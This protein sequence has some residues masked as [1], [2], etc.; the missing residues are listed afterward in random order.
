MP[1]TLNECC[2]C[3]ETCSGACHKC[4]YHTS[5]WK[6]NPNPADFTGCWSGWGLSLPWYLE[7]TPTVS[8]CSYGGS[9]QWG[10][11]CHYKG[12]SGSLIAS[13]GYA[14]AG[15]N[16]SCFLLGASE[17]WYLTLDDGTKAL[18]YYRA[19]SICCEASITF[20][21][22]K[23]TSGCVG[24]YPAS[25]TLTECNAP[26]LCTNCC[27]PGETLPNALTLT[28]GG[29]GCE[30]GTLTL[31]YKTGTSF[32]L[33]LINNSWLGIQTFPCNTAFK[34]FCDRGANPCAWKLVSGNPNL[35]ATYSVISTNCNPF[36][37]VFQRGGNNYTVTL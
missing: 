21:F 11:G 30:G 18:V 4:A 29:L 17:G 5:S 37:V 2:Q 10:G 3:C 23:T 20:D 15:A 25:I 32:G 8:R 26:C 6:Y 9:V 31:N 33:S 14:E 7:S 1:T 16:V 22:L 35:T 12:S 28:L 24:T 27:C 13:F 19:G 36:Q 34:F